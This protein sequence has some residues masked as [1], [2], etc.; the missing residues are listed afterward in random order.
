[1][2]LF[3]MIIEILFY[4]SIFSLIYELKSNVKIYLESQKKDNKEMIEKFDNIDMKN[5]IQ[6]AYSSIIEKQSAMQYRLKNELP[7]IPCILTDR[8]TNEEIDCYFHYWGRTIQTMNNDDTKFYEITVAFIE[9]K[10]NG[11][12]FR[13]SV[14]SIRFSRNIDLTNLENN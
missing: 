12:M 2:E 8:E 13:S 1:M 9:R 5:I 4:V 10:D 11:K 6:D 7:K 3:K 14:D